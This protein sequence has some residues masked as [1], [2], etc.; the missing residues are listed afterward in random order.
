MSYTNRKAL[1]A[2][3]EEMRNRPLITYVTS[4]R[5]GLSSQMAGDA[6]PIMIDQINK[7]PAN[8]EDIDFL[9]VSN[10]GDPITSLQIISILRER[11][12]TITVIVPYVAYSAATI[13]ALGADEIIMH[14]YSN[15]GPVD[16]QLT[17]SRQNNDGQASNIQF[18]SED[19]R[20]YIEFVKS[21]VGITDQNHLMTAFNAL[22]EE[23]GPLPIGSS[24][25]SQQLS[26][27]LSIKML[28]SHIADKNKAATIAQTLNTSY[29]HHGYA[30][31]RR[32]AKEI[33]LNIVYPER[34]L[35][36]IIWGI[37]QDFNGEM[38][39]TVEFN[40]VTEIMNNPEARRRIDSIPIVQIPGNL[41]PDL[42]QNVVSQILPQVLTVD[43][44]TP[45]ELN[46]LLASIESERLASFVY[47]TIRVIYWRD[48]NMCLSF[49]V[50]SFSDGWKSET[51]E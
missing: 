23:V 36:N 40:P 25:R 2:S 49:N 31:G 18:G 17:I 11:F 1:Y 46:E 8:E 14:P 38:K 34:E 45:I 27:S 24:K 30:V 26:L 32:E 4:I 12:K 15:L 21:D 47:T 9:I 35:E 42:A 13:L 51:G 7:I 28:E 41:P 20:N 39:C 19:V 5:P 44:Q 48:I 43:Q 3:W 22:A 33:G 37:W 10:G 16:P 29:Y 50:T 6:V